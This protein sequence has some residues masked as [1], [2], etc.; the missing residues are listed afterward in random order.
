MKPVQIVDQ[1][2]HPLIQAF[3][4]QFRILWYILIYSYLG[5]LCSCA[6]LFSSPRQ[7][8]YIQSTPQGA[9]IIIDGEFKG[10]TPAHTMVDREFSAVMEGKK[11]IQLEYPGY[12]KTGYWLDATINPISFINLTNVLFWAIDAAT[13]SIAKY[14]GSNMYNLVPYQQP[15]TPANQKESKYDRLIKLKKL[16]EEGIL[17]PEEYQK[18]KYKILSEE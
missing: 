16:Q 8:V 15:N 5:S 12:Q 18:E 3:I 14:S 2:M 1:M 7:Q 4:Y 11:E 6:T 17:T 13:G 9:R 10:L